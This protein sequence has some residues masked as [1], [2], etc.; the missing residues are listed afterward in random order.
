MRLFICLLLLAVAPMA[1]AQ[2]PAPREEHT[3]GLRHLVFETGGG[4]PAQA[5]PLIVALHYSGARPEVLVEAFGDLRVPARIV[6]PQGPHPRPQGHSWFPQGYGQ[7]SADEQASLTR[8][9]E[10]RVFDFIRAVEARYPG[11]GKTIV[12]GVSYGGDL[13]FLLALDH[14]DRFRAAFPVAARL[15][16]E[17][18]PARPGCAPDCPVLHALH[19]SDDA[20]VPI[21]PTRAAVETLRARGFDADLVAYP[22]TAHDFSA[23][24]QADLRARIEAMLRSP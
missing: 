1:L 5:L 6:L 8:N 15:L 20:T 2:A 22:G 13:A 3:G 21:G 24:M 19:G 4:D 16:P 23:D 10:Q 14:P 9:G 7:R 11:H 18:L 17:W 12:T